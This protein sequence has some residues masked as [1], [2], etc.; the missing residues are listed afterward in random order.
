[1]INRTV[2]KKL[3]ML[4]WGTHAIGA[5]CVIALLCAAYYAYGLLGRERE[6]LDARRRDDLSLVAR[7]EQVR[8]DREAAARQLQSFSDT[9]ND[10]KSRLPSS[11][12]EAEFLAQLSALAERSGVRLRNFR[13]GQVTPASSVSTCDVQ[14]SLV[15]SF[16][17]ICKLLDGTREVPRFLSVA[18]LN[19]TG[20]QSAGEACV[21]DVT[22]SLCF[23]AAANK[24]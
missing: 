18:R 13:P 15:G 12:K 2:Q 22:I 23:A 20:P 3:T 6:S 4:V 5:I 8:A 9:L 17:S 10:L 7:A 16:A 1:M 21:A 19:L 11:P 14:L 24:Q